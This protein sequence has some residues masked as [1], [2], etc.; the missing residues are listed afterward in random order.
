[1]ER[2]IRDTLLALLIGAVISGGLHW[3]TGH[4]SLAVAAGICWVVGLKL[5]LHSRYLYPGFSAGDTWSSN[6]WSVL[7]I[8]LTNF[9]ALLGVSPML[10]ISDKLRLG[11]GFLVAGVG[12]V[13]YSAGT[14]AVLEYDLGDSESNPITPS[15]TD[16]D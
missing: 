2:Q 11:L 1:M 15:A 7:A 9:T 13:T 4:I 3:F 6:R 12:L 10:P 8:G 5:A 16:S 14:L